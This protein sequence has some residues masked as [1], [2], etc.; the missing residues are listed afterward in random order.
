MNS[1]HIFMGEGHFGAAVSAPPI[2]RW[3]ARR[4]AVSVPDISAP[5]HILFLFFK[6]RGKNNEA[7]NFLNA[8]ER[9]SVETR[10]LNPT[11]SEASE[12][13]NNVG[14]IFHKRNFPGGTFLDGIFLGGI[15]LA[16]LNPTARFNPTGFDQCKMS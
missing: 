14:G 8:V 3:T 4:R 16:P 1:S 13:R 5:F 6:L 15:Y 11:A 12:L 2:R 10:V 9:E 7:G